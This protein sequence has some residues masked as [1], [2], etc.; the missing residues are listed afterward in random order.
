MAFLG[1]PC[2]AATA[3]TAATAATAATTGT[4]ATT[5]A[6]ISAIPNSAVGSTVA[7]VCGSGAR[8]VTVAHPCATL[9]T[10]YDIVAIPPKLVRYGWRPFFDDHVFHD[11]HG[12]CCEDEVRDVVAA[13]WVE[14]DLQPLVQWSVEAF[15]LLASTLPHRD[16]LQVCWLFAVLVRASKEGVLGVVVRRGPDQGPT[17][18]SWKSRGAHV[19]PENWRDDGRY[20][21][22]G[23]GGPE[24][25]GPVNRCLAGALTGGPRAPA[26]L[27]GGG[28]PYAGPGR[29]LGR[30]K[31]GS[32]QVTGRHTVVAAYSAWSS[33]FS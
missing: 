5:G 1:S 2:I 29:G 16:E 13:L 17:G 32:Q 24:T 7:A 19:T 10:N 27:A 28:S 20:G 33:Y 3:V 9:T 11:A 21:T 18:T 23:G 26:P 30:R 4:T 6:N 22:R 8:C 14:C 25:T 31:R 12:L 15:E